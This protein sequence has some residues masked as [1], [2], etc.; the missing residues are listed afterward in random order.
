MK[1]KLE[2]LA[3]IGLRM[4]SGAQ[5]VE[6]I[7]NKESHKEQ[8]IGYW[9]GV[10]NGVDGRIPED[11]SNSYKDKPQIPYIIIHSH[12]GRNLV[13]THEDKPYEIYLGDVEGITILTEK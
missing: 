3:K 11:Y 9:W 12:L 1:Y 6:V 2:D 4:V 13:P 8:I 7:F 5:K 10:H